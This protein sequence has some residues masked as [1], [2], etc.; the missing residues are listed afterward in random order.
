VGP[1]GGRAWGYAALCGAAIGLCGLGQWALTRST[2][3]AIGL[4]TYLAGLALLVHL[5]W[6]SV[7]DAPAPAAIPGIP[8]PTRRQ[9]TALAVALVAAVAVWILTSGRHEDADHTDVTIAWLVAIG[10]ALAAAVPARPWGWDARRER[11]RS[12]AMAPHGI[13]AG[14]LVVAAAW[15]RLVG[16]GRFP[17]VEG[18][19]MTLTLIARQVLDGEV[20]NPFTTSWFFDNPTLYAHLQADVLRVLGETLVAAR[21]L[22][23]LVGTATVAVTYLWARRLLGP[24]PALIATVLLAVFHMHLYFSRIALNVVEDAFFAAVVLWLLDRALVERRRVDALFAGF[25]VGF[26][27]YFYLSGRVLLPATAAA[28]GA[29]AWWWRGRT[30]SWRAAWEVVARPSAWVAFGALVVALPLVAH[31]ADQP[32]DYGSRYRQVAFLGGWLEQEQERTGRSAGELVVDQVRR[33]AL[34]PFETEP[35]GHYHP[36]APLVGAPMAVPTALGVAVAT[37]GLRKR[38]HTMIAVLWW[39]SLAGVGLTVGTHSQRWIVAVPLVAVMAGIGLDAIHRTLTERAGLPGR[40]VGSGIATVVAALMVWNLAV[41]FQD[42]N[43]TDVWGDL[44]STVADEL[45]HTLD[46]VPAGTAVYTAF[47]PRMSFASH[48]TVPY[49][50]DHVVG[51]D[52]VEPLRSISDVPPVDGRTVFAFLPERR[53]ELDIV[54]SAHPG[55]TVSERIAHDGEP[56]FTVYD[57]RPT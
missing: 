45:A 41:F 54:R 18:D 10:A 56:L 26:A 24:R 36:D 4:G 38:R 15:A 33:A 42:T 6:S 9:R 23:A 19:G 35:I 34:L 43:T 57:V 11:W 44:N 20:R 27:Q 25:A 46:G 16:L 30:A 55:G 12:A 37:A 14:S 17:S 48:S 3:L 47:A 52:L 28:I 21:L 31:Y 40:W 29:Y 7:D 50:A 22:S 13:L 5:Q 8:G 32:E 49:L 2:P 51:V 53:A 1:A 39:G